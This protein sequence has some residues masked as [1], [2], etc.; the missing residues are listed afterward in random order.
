MQKNCKIGLKLWSTNTDHYYSEAKKLYSQGVFDY[1]ELYVVPDTMETLVKWKVLDIPFIIHAPHSLH[2]FN[3]ALSEKEQLNINLAN[4]AKEFA[5]TLNAEYIIFHG[6]CDGS[7]EE[8]IRQ[9]NLLNEPRG[10]IENKPFFPIPNSLGLKKCRGA[11]TKDIT[12]ILEN[13]DFCFCLDIAHAVCAANA[14]HIN[15]YDYIAQ[16]EKLKPVIYHISDGDIQSCQDQHLSFG[17]GNYDFSVIFQI[18]KVKTGIFSIE[19]Q[20][21]S[22]YNLSD[23]VMDRNFI[24]GIV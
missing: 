4:Q 24:V 18:I 7:I 10:L 20:K 22:I 8:V 23:F 21:K 11:S 2:G 17:N 16:F 12:M 9:I 13:T 19:T 14:F 5:D 1:I 15:P 3:L 6:G